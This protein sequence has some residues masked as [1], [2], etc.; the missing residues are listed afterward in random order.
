M[1]KILSR[2]LTVIFFLGIFSFLVTKPV[3]GAGSL[4]LSPSSSTVTQGSD[5]TVSLRVSSGSKV[6][7]IETRIT[8]PANKLDF[9]GFGNGSFTLY[10]LSKG[11]SGSIYVVA[12]VSGSG[13]SGSNLVATIKFRAKVSS[14]TASVSINKSGSGLAGSG[15]GANLL[16]SVA[17]GTYTFKA[18]PPPPKPKAQDKTAPKVSS[19][20]VTKLTRT[21]A[22]IAWATNEDSDSTV[23]WGPT[24]KYGIIAASSKLTKS[25]AIALDKRLLEPGTAVHYRVIS[26][27]GSGNKGVSTDQS[28]T[29]PGYQVQIK[30]V[31]KDGVPIEG[32]KVTLVSYGEVGTDE[33]GAANYKDV[34]DGERAVLV[35]YQGKSISQIVKVAQ[36]DGVQTFEVKVAGA[37]AL[38]GLTTTQMLG[39]GLI[40]IA[41]LVAFILFMFRGRLTRSKE[42]VDTNL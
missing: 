38:Q 1:I 40:G 4:S 25:H 6:N 33:K 9:L 21:S 5:F 13:K 8:Y 30:V 14:G 35:D 42:E 22:T 3:L 2:F 28:F 12:G 23:E 10:D 31:D 7:A 37:L 24:S 41:V 39:L 26:K 20:K 34:E 36:K 29:V 18:A 15:S 16:T 27:D 17:G 19:V 32:A 11:G